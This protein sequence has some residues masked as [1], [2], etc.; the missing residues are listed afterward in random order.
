MRSVVRL[1][2]RLV[3][4]GGAAIDVSVQVDRTCTVGELADQLADRIG[5]PFGATVASRWPIDGRDRPPARDRLVVDAGPRAGSTVVLVEAPTAA[6]DDRPVA[7]VRLEGEVRALELHYGSN[8]L[9]DTS[10]QVG[11]RVE[12]HDLGASTARINGATLLGSARI[13]DGDLL[14][15]QDRWWTVRVDDALRPPP[16]AGAWRTHTP[17]PAVGPPDETSELVL[18]SPPAAMR[19]PGFPVLSATVPLLMGIGLWVATRSLAAA[20]F[21]IFSFVFVVA[22]GVEAR[23]EARAEDRFREAEFRADLA[24]A[25]HAIEERRAAQAARTDRIVPPLTTLRSMVDDPAATPGLWQRSAHGSTLP[26]EDLLRV[27]LGRGPVELDSPIS[28]PEGGRRDLRLE[29]GSIATALRRLDD[30][31]TIDLAASGGLAIVGPGEAPA[32]VARAITVQLACALAP[33]ALSVAVATTPA[34]RPTW[35]WTEWLAHRS[36]S[37]P[38][39]RGERSALLVV[40]G[41]SGAQAAGGATA[42][43]CDAPT[44]LWVGSDPSDVPA[45]LTRILHV[46]GT[47]AVLVDPGGATSWGE[48][49][50]LES[51]TLDEAEPIARSLA[52]IDVDRD[53]RGGRQDV[54]PGPVRLADV[55]V[56]PALLVDADAVR[57]RWARRTAGLSVPLAATGS[58]GAAPAVVSLD[59]V[60]DGPH[61]LVA[62]TTGAGKSEL[63]RTLLVSAGLHHPPDRLHYLLIDY[64]G[65]A[66]FGPLTALPHTVGII[67]DLTPELARRA[68]V[69]L[70]AEVRRREEVLAAEARSDW[71]GTALVVVVDEFAT[72]AN[73]LPE[74]VDGLV[75]VAQRGRSLGVHLVLA[76]QRP[77]GVVTDSIRANTTLRIALRVADE[78]DSRDVVESPI[79]ASFPRDAPGRAVLRVGPQ[80]SVVAQVAWCG[81]PLQTQEPAVVHDLGG[82]ESIGSSGAAM[83]AP[84]AR[85]ERTELDLA[86]RT[87]QEAACGT[88]PPRRPWLD[89]LAGRVTWSDVDATIER[90]TPQPTGVPVGLVDRPEAQDRHVMQAALARDG[91]VMVIGASGSG[92]S[93]TVAAVARALDHVEEDWQVYVVASAPSVAP[94]GLLDEVASVGDVVALHDV[95]RVSRLLR[96]TCAEMDDRRRGIGAEHDGVDGRPRPRRLVVVDGMGAFEELYERIDRGAAVDAVARLARDG[97]AV[98]IHL[99]IT[100]SRPAEVPTT[101]A[102]G[103]GARWWLRVGSIDDAALAGLPPAAADPEQ[104]PGRCWVDGHVAQVVDPASIPPGPAGTRGAAPSVPRLPSTIS[105]AALAGHASP[106]PLLATIAVDADTLA[107]VALDLRNHHAVI[108]GPPR[109]GRSTALASLAAA[110]PTALLCSARSGLAELEQTVRTALARV[111]A[112]TST[113]VAVDDLPELLD[114]PDADVASSLLGDVVRAGRELP[115]RLVVSGD[116]DALLRCYSEVVTT[117]RSGRT[118]LVL[119]DDA[120]AHAHLLHAEPPPRSDLPSGPGRGWLLGPGAARPAQ[121]A[122][123]A[124]VPA[125][126]ADAAFSPASATGAR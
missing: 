64:K 89:P 43:A 54:P 12:V 16:D 110:V 14:R 40:D 108:A 102:A 6:T 100:A 112:G 45:Q 65:G 86:V 73:E 70:R 58:D 69:S 66:A 20:V 74:F 56:D 96:A 71:T 28:V 30:V 3:V 10:I 109:S 2:M 72:L 11:S 27:R 107:P 80:R 84:D 101:V 111:R 77:A 33:D 48:I 41:L 114:G 29:L 25:V 95:E 126:A 23:R 19:I 52:S 97:R 90:S 26:P 68:L 105:L 46:D 22:S 35:A 38:P 103:L 1:P 42:G 24:D 113:V 63:L 85:A 82:G 87:I 116:P 83:P 91:G 104:P 119:G 78:D 18:P 115:L 55:V 8:Q 44:M 53:L 34:R 36:A 121:V 47:S 5:A 50:H 49:T 92:R 13:V 60:A 7:P 76:T 81:G 75:D 117:L 39:P 120:A 31:V 15:L 106:D 17:R 79:A 94:L 98:G 123:A 124:G 21:V 61:V 125:T 99:M 67:T 118:G 122:V 51:A 93:S 57:A 59:L 88:T 4:D 62:G 32:A 9:G 37:G